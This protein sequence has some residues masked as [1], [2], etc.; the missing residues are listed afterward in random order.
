MLPFAA[1]L[2][3]TAIGQTFVIQQ[4]GVDF[5]VPGTV[6]LAAVMM[7]KFADQ[8]TDRILTALVVVMVVAAC[9]GLVN[10]F[11]VTRIGVPPVIATLGVN[12]L[13]VGWMRR[14]SGGLSVPP[15]PDV[16]RDFALGK[17]LALP[18]PMWVA[19]VVTAVAT[20]ALKKTIAGRRFDATG[21]NSAA[22]RISGVSVGPIRA[23][24]YVLASLC[25]ATAGVLL[26]SYL[27]APRIDAGEPY[28]LGS[29]AATVI[30]GTSL[31]GGA[32]SVVGALVG[33]LFLT[34]LSQVLL[35][36]GL[37]SSVNFVV[38]G[39]VIA[40]AM[41]IRT[42]VQAWRRRQSSSRA[43]DDS[44]RDDRTKELGGALLVG[45]DA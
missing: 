45:R 22:A 39:I 31:A 12:A 7:T 21:A 14:Y 35:G 9:I 27:S 42:A 38:Q 41:G 28:L 29:I 23:S 30:G 5:S 18:N 16:M 34:Q 43:L 32:G 6:S 2:G 11:F 1:I 25:Y 20:V 13:V 40:L 19:I 8:N 26:A 33:A 24:A 44:S 17:T 37:N 15:A 4:G 3:I 10:A 36:S